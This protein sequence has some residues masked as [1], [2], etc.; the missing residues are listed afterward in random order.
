MVN[1]LIIGKVWPEPRSTAA[2]RRTQDVIAALQAQDVAGATSL[3][4][5]SDATLVASSTT[6]GWQVHFASAAQ[7]GAHA[8]DLE[9]LGVQTHAIAVND[10]AFDSWIAALNPDVVI[11]DRFM[12]E[13]QFGWRVAEQCPD[14]LRVLETSDLHCLRVARE[15]VLKT[16]EPLQLKNEI[17]L[18]EIASIYRS[19]LT[20][21]ISEFEMEILRGEFAIPDELLAYWPFAL[22]LSDQNAPYESRKD[23]ILI[24]SFMHPPNLDAARWCKREIWPLIRR[25]LPEAELHCYGSYGDRYANELNAPKDGF[26]FKGRAE[27]ALETMAQ[28]RVNLAP[29]RYGAGLKGKVFDGFQTGTPNLMTPIAAEGVCADEAHVHADAGWFAAAAVR[30]YQDLEHWCERQAQ[31]QQLCRSRFNQ[32][33]WRPILV[34]FLSVALAEKQMRRQKNFTG[35]MLRHHQHRSTEFMSRWIEAKNQ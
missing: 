17:A 5:C 14:A 23:F 8:L 16:G 13:E 7:R 33:Y 34:E 28:Y 11:F 30:L 12:T 4:S 24:G 26:L 31:E 20:L 2:G 6:D 19:D 21:M 15:E 29:L 10:S 35:Q 9:S 3:H 18:R 1:C 27:D 32:S 25:Q 22:E